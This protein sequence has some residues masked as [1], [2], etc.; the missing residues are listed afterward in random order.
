[1]Y[2][3]YSASTAYFGLLCLAIVATCTV[4]GEPATGEET[5]DAYLKRM[6]S[7]N[8]AKNNA[9]QEKERLAIWNEQLALYK[10]TGQA[11]Y[12]LQLISLDIPAED[13]IPA[14]IELLDS[15]DVAARQSALGALSKYGAKAAPAIDPIIKRLADPDEEVVWRTIEA[16]SAIGHNAEAV[17]V[18]PFVV[19]LQGSPSV[20]NRKAIIKTLGK[21][22]P[23]AQKAIP[24]LEKELR[25]R[26]TFVAYEA[27]LALGAIRNLPP[28]EK[29]TFDEHNI[30]LLLD[31]T[32]GYSAFQALRT[33]ILDRMEA[34]R[35]LNILLLSPRKTPFQVVH[36]LK[37]LAILKPSDEK[38]IK[39]VFDD[40]THSDEAIA[41]SALDTLIASDYSAEECLKILI[42]GL[43]PDNPALVSFV[44]KAM[45]P[46]GRKAEPAVPVI[47]SHLQ[48]AQDDKRTLSPDVVFGY[49]SVL[50]SVGPA[51]ADSIPL[52]ANLLTL[53]NALFQG[54][55]KG[56]VTFLR[57][58]MLLVLSDIAIPD[59]ATPAIIDELSNG[60]HAA[61]VAVAAH[62]AG[63]MTKHQEHVVP[64]LIKLLNRESDWIAKRPVDLTKLAK[65]FFSDGE[66][67]TSARLEAIRSLGRLGPLSKAALPALQRIADDPTPPNATIYHHYPRLQEEA[68][69][70][71]EAIKK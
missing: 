60:D 44:C 57:A 27:Y 63:A 47:I 40:L 30:D 35:L 29:S 56:N 70:A 6:R 65:D 62:A 41:L 11:S 21:F 14:Y 12:L 42:G 50:R 17:A 46:L 43:N 25:N 31:D 32:K 24:Q 34:I 39:A 18:D 52:I 45:T 28:L 38:T 10:K 16:I 64:L 8:Q 59:G 55:P 22:G 3:R 69:K 66:P 13:G 2:I 19:Q 68:A 58:Q 61:G 23:A 7:A 1:M 33:G 71:I 49:L 20:R 36:A 48:R 53:D 5:Y 4:S 15:P 37:S 67:R 54:Q 26:D 51:A 9:I